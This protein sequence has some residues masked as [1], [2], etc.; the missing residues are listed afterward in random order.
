MTNHAADT[1]APTAPTTFAAAAPPPDDLAERES[2]PDDTQQDTE[3]DYLCLEW[4]AWCRTRR[5]Y[6]PA[7]VSGTVLGKLSSKISPR[8]RTEHAGPACRMDLAALHLAISAQ[9][10]AID[11]QVFW[12]AYVHNA[13]PIKQAAYALSISRQHWYRL[14]RDFRRRV[15]AA[16]RE[17]QSA[18]EA[19]RD[20]LPH[21]RQAA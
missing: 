14:L 5:F 16:A 10:N 2:L 9:P 3:L 6:G 11:K 20:A 1:E 18:E 8:R 13:S 12:L 4:A 19:A 7:P 21:Y 15:W 17:I